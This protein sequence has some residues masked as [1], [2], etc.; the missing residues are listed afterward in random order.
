MA[1]AEGKKVG[2]KWRLW[3]HRIGYVATAI[4]LAELLLIGFLCVRGWLQQREMRAGKI[5]ESRTHE[6]PLSSE[7]AGLV[8]QSAIYLLGKLSATD[9]LHGDGIRFVAMPSFN[10]SHFAVAIHMPE[11]TANDAEGIVSRFDL[12]NSDAPLSQRSF[13]IPAST[14]RSLVAKMDRLTDGYPGEAR[15]CLDGTP[16]AFERVRGRRIT[17]GIGNCSDHYERVASLMW[18]YLSR[19]A[20]AD[21]LPARGDWEPSSDEEGSSE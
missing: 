19:F 16:V 20:P 9:A 21:D 18:N 15:W 11:P 10:R 8:H 17:S 12:R 1:A 4:V 5:E 2:R 14:Y 7:D 3:L 13:S 6:G